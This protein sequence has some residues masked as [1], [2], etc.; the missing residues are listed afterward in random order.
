MLCR[1]SQVS[2]NHQKQA[3]ALMLSPSKDPNG[4]DFGDV[5]FDITTSVIVLSKRNKNRRKDTSASAGAGAGTSASALASASLSS[6]L[7]SAAQTGKARKAGGTTAGTAA[8]IATTDGGQSAIAAAS[9]AVAASHS[10]S[11]KLIDDAIGKEDIDKLS[12]I[13]GIGIQVRTRPH[14]SRETRV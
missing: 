8:P 11:Q 3:F 10:R 13:P 6:S 9:A 14:A 5:S 12:T 7:V 2:K 1:V 4:E